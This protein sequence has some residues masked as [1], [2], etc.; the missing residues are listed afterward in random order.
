MKVL[1]SL[2][3]LIVISLFDT[4][5][6][7]TNIKECVGQELLGNPSETTVS[8][9]VALQNTG[10]ELVSE[11][12][13]GCGLLSV[14]RIESEGGVIQRLSLPDLLGGLNN[15]KL[16]FLGITW[17]LP[18]GSS[19]TGSSVDLS[20]LSAGIYEMS[21]CYSYLYTS[22]DGTEESSG[23]ANK[24]EELTSTSF[25][26]FYIPVSFQFEVEGE[27]ACSNEHLSGVN[28]EGAEALNISG[29]NYLEDYYLNVGA[30]YSEGNL[31]MEL[32]ELSF[33]SSGDFTLEGYWVDYGDG[34]VDYKDKSDLLISHNY[35]LDCGESYSGS[36]R[37]CFVGRISGCDKRYYVGYSRDISV[38]GPSCHN[39]DYSITVTN[40]GCGVYS[41]SYEGLGE[42]LVIS[43][44]VWKIRGEEISGNSYEFT[45]NGFVEV[46]LVDGNDASFVP[47]VSS[48]TVLDFPEV[49]FTS[50]Y[51]C[52]SGSMDLSI[53][54][55]D[56]SGNN[57]YWMIDGEF[58]QE[59]GTGS[60][61]LNVNGSVDVLLHA[62]ASSG[63]GCTRSVSRE[64][65]L[66][67]S[68]G[69]TLGVDYCSGEQLEP[70]NVAYGSEFNWEL[71]DLSDENNT[72]VYSSSGRYFSKDLSEVTG[73]ISSEENYQLS[74]TYTT[75]NGCESS[76]SSDF[77]VHPEVMGE[78]SSSYGSCGNYDVS[79]ELTN[80]LGADNYGVNYGDGD[81]DPSTALS[82][83]SVNFSHTYP[84]SGSYQTT[85]TLSNSGCSETLREQ[86]LLRSTPEVDLLG[87]T[88]FC[89]GGNQLLTARINSGVDLSQAVYTWEYST[90]LEGGY[91]ELSSGSTNELVAD[92]GGFYRVKVS[93]G[94]GCGD[95]VSISKEVKEVALVEGSLSLVSGVTCYDKT[96]GSLELEVP[97]A[98]A[99]QGY[100]IKPAG[101]TSNQSVEQLTGLPSGSN[102]ITIES[103][104]NSACRYTMSAE[105]PDNGPSLSA[106]LI[107]PSTCDNP[108]GSIDL[109][110]S[111]GGSNKV[112][113][114][115][116]LSGSLP[117]G[118]LDQADLNDVPSGDYSVRY[119]DENGCVLHRE[120]NIP[121]VGLSSVLSSNYLS[122]CPTGLVEF[123]VS[124]TYTPGGYTPVSGSDFVYSMKASESSAGY[125]TITPTRQEGNES[126]FELSVGVYEF[127]VLDNTT[128]CSN[129]F[130]VEISPLE[131]II[132]DFV[133][134]APV[135]SDDQGSLLAEVQGGSG[136]YTYSWSSNSRS[137]DLG[138]SNVVESVMNGEVYRLSISDEKGCVGQS[139]YT[140][141]SLS[142]EPLSLS[143]EDVTAN[144]CN[145]SVSVAGGV[146]PYNYTW[147]IEDDVKK[148]ESNGG[149]SFSSRIEREL[150]VAH[151]HGG[152]SPG[153][154]ESS[155]F[156]KSGVYQLT[157]NDYYGCEEELEV[158]LA[159]SDPTPPSFSF[160]FG[161]TYEQD[162]TEEPELE[163][164]VRDNMQEASE[165]LSNIMASCSEKK[166]AGVKQFYE[167]TCMNP[168]EF[169]DAFTVSYSEDI[170]HY[171]LYYYDRAGRLTKTV[172]PEGVELLTTSE[173]ASVKS[174]SYETDE[175]NKQHRLVTSYAYN[176]LGQLISQETPDGNA[177]TFL[178]DKEN[179]LRFSQNAEQKNHDLMSYTKY[180]NLGRVIEA[181]ESSV[182]SV[183]FSK[184]SSD[185][186]TY[187]SDNSYP[188]NAR[189]EYVHTVYTDEASNVSY[190]NQPQRFL[191][192]RV[193]YTYKDEDGDPNTESDRYATYYSYDPHGNVEWLIQE[194]PILGKNY[195]SYEY[196]L[197]SG[198]VMEVKYNENGPD[199]FYHRYRYDLDNRLVN[200]E[201]SRDG[202]LWEEDA[203]YDYYA[204]G[205]LKRKELGDDHVQGEDYAYTVEGWLKMKNSPF[206]DAESSNYDMHGDGSVVDLSDPLSVTET[207]KDAYGMALGYY[208]GDYNVNSSMNL[209]LN[210]L[211]SIEGVS[212][213][214]GL[215]NGNIRYWSNSLSNA[216]GD[217][218]LSAKMNVYDYDQLNRLKQSTEYD[219]SGTS[220]LAS[221]NY[222]SSYEYD[223]NGNIEKLIRNNGS[224]EEIDRLDYEYDEVEGKKQ[225]NQLKRVVDNSG[226]AA[227]DVNDIKG[228]TSYEYD[229][230]GNLVKETG[231]T[232]KE[233]NGVDQICDVVR[234][235]TWNVS[236]KVEQVS[237]EVS[238]EES[239]VEKRKIRFYYDAQGNRVRK[240]VKRTSEELSS[241]DP[242]L[243]RTYFYVRDASGNLMG[244]YAR[245]NEI[246]DLA[247]ESYEA[248]FKLIERP[249]YGSDRLGLDKKQE[250]I[251]VVP[252]TAGEEI[253]LEERG[254][255]NDGLTYKSSYTNWVLASESTS[256]GL[257]STRLTS[258]G[259][260][261]TGLSAIL[262]EQELS[263]KVGE[264]VAIAENFEGELQFYALVA[265]NYLGSGENYLLLFD[266]HGDLIEGTDQIKGVDADCHP[267]V[268]S[269]PGSDLYSVVTLKED[270][271]LYTHG[272]DMSHYGYGVLEP[273]GK[274]VSVDEPMS[275]SG[276]VYG[277]H[278]TGYEDH[279]NNRVIVYATQMEEGYTEIENKSRLF[280]YEYV[281]G[282][283][284][285][286]EIMS[287]PE[288]CGSNKDGEL[289]LS[290][291]GEYIGWYYHGKKVGA[292]DYREVILY[293]IPLSNDKL[294]M[295]GDYEEILSDGSGNLSG[296]GS[297][298]FGLNQGKLYF[299]QNGVSEGGNKIQQYDLVSK[300]LLNVPLGQMDYLLSDIRKSKDGNLYVGN[301]SSGEDLLSS[302][303][304]SNDGEEQAVST[305]LSGDN[306]YTWTGDLPTQVLK[307]GSDRSTQE[308]R[309][310]I[311]DKVY[312]L[313]DHLGNVRVVID[314]KKKVTHTLDGQAYF[315]SNIKSANN[316]YPFGMQMPGRTFSSDEY[317]YGFQGQEKDDEVKGEGNSINYKFR[318]HDPRIGRFFAVDPLAAKYPWNSVYAFS[319]NRVIDAIE[320]E[321]LESIAQD[322][323]LRAQEEHLSH[324]SNKTSSQLQ[325]LTAEELFDFYLE[326]EEDI[327]AFLSTGG[328]IMSVTGEILIFIPVTSA[329]G[330]TMA[331]VGEGMVIAGTTLDVAR[332]TREGNYAEAGGKAFLGLAGVGIGKNLRYL[333]ETNKISRTDR[334]I[335]SITSTGVGY[336]Y[337]MALDPDF[338]KKGLENEL[339]GGYIDISRMD[340]SSGLLSL[341]HTPIQMTRVYTI[342]SGDTLT[343]IAKQNKTTVEAI[344]AENNI[345]DVD[346]IYEG[347][348]LSITTTSTL[349]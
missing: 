193:S 344:A 41:F 106:D 146:S 272:V 54:D 92:V 199:A 76:S 311:G 183:D 62:T 55:Y 186:E 245:K 48:F 31:I 81:S 291:K 156:E 185:N 75:S 171:T 207:A 242:V 145:V 276:G 223:A 65:S 155:N 187:T 97:E 33:L 289:Q 262:N 149:L 273:L 84:S 166:K 152:G 122:A 64:L 338:N 229:D 335:L 227:T 201:T 204:H 89:Q 283:W 341:D 349:N 3:F 141:E 169:K 118:D 258:M 105:V 158:S 323:H 77:T 80:V 13:S 124:T 6:S 47:V 251:A 228:S 143:P 331:A 191:R 104:I 167:K 347:D 215:Y 20:G 211:S 78:L 236:G 114:W 316:Y 119:E 113:E 163:Q 263:A 321:G 189:T 277:N 7:Q 165:S 345:E 288:S 322:I 69:F 90:T 195:L 175:V 327:I 295:D 230:I 179:R 148:Y 128:G 339:P 304:I 337:G 343:E 1:F 42:S 234:D 46:E 278:F 58:Q 79:Y 333:R 72:V 249:I 303:V 308:G 235:I 115:E 248:K 21:A 325:P 37:I 305:G 135:C 43:N 210:A 161:G 50:N 192:N 91:T 52:T 24:M 17:H 177:T 287:L 233:V 202:V 297:L 168:S 247:S 34:E 216:D 217:G 16:T 190:Y 9:A 302:Y 138:S 279:I 285:E 39:Q 268:V 160:V 346:E 184:S 56:P 301:L 102:F 14:E 28:L 275:H 244:M 231:K 109:T 222:K 255:S 280:A 200:V 194:D 153:V 212:G 260:D 246:I 87:G 274:V 147:R 127:Q 237:I 188:S 88:S 96:D 214:E 282:S 314:D 29:R 132:I 348:N 25:V 239:L 334:G 18:D 49:D 290:S 320:L 73:D 329:L 26:V 219:Q 296:G 336:S 232:I 66:G 196:D 144:N 101:I 173:I 30:S 261:D 44:P 117:S 45:Q 68:E 12:E 312:E 27:K 256:D 140:V 332:S 238:Y 241:Y 284:E 266:K 226:Y 218:H 176:S 317:R 294:S 159:F 281:D 130:T 142:S 309:R 63:E 315:V 40:T 319:N 206:L 257:L 133:L 324:F 306:G 181:G 151:S 170:Y 108:S 326:Y 110:V 60:L 225:T 67:G 8:E 292:F 137:D 221:T 32:P 98:L 224:G 265:K 61:E 86:V 59:S 270:G 209:G 328:A 139:D 250:D 267:V 198:N 23:G 123:S 103:S 254:I 310:Y 121:K 51:N 74:L 259:M 94:S 53:T 252:F 240:E 35:N 286:H 253:R 180:D 318:M 299:T 154:T 4:L 5:Y 340:N 208:S 36:I 298:A 264:G 205:P 111:S 125:E 70:S 330:V 85:V 271:R 293:Q 126:Y 300:S 19:E 213:K 174:G 178:Y 269:H 95:L 134:D 342:Q 120:Y 100:V 157:V 11:S 150:V 22:G 93:L 38:T 10:L 162:D 107:T 313:K 57:Y 71:I 131:P 203:R 243:E 2:S 136:S 220:W 172:P 99:S 182:G 116:Y 197:V 129:E 83:S 82:G 15:S 307:V 164:D 112:Y